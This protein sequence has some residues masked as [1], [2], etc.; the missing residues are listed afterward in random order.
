MAQSILPEPRG[1]EAGGDRDPGRAPWQSGGRSVVRAC[2]QVSTSASHSRAPWS[3]GPRSPRRGRVDR[4][5][6]L[7]SGRR[8]ALIAAASSTVPGRG[9]GCRRPV[10]DDRQEPVVV[11]GPVLPVQLLLGLAFGGVGVG[12][13]DQVPG[14][15]GQVGRVQAGR[16]IEEERLPVRRTGVGGEPVDR[17]H[18]HRACS[19]DPPATIAAWVA[20]L[21]TRVGVPDGLVAG[22]AVGAGQVGEPLRGRPPRQL[23]WRPRGRAP[24]PPPRLPGR[25]GGRGA[26]GHPP[27]RPAPPRLRDP[28]RLVD[29]QHGSGS[30]TPAG[31]V[32]VP[33][34]CSMTQLNQRPPTVRGR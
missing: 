11:G 32:G 30:G 3:R 1:L 21:V 18:D 15:L 8:A 34:G 16:G 23:P 14:G 2:R 24:R 26:L 10:L 12:D 9:A 4:G 28:H 20:T 7:V 29:R 19:G 25:R 6:G 22:A 33:V 31:V 13:L 27:P 17:V 5:G